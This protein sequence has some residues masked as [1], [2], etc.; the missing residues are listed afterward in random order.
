MSAINSI[1]RVYQGSG[2]LPSA[3]NSS[4]NNFTNIS[5]SCREPLGTEGYQFGVFENLP[6]ASSFALTGTQDDNVSTMTGGPSPMKS[7][8]T[9]SSFFRSPLKWFIKRSKSGD[10]FNGDAAVTAE[11]DELPPLDIITE[12]A[13]EKDEDGIEAQAENPLDDALLVDGEVDPI[14]ETYVQYVYYSQDY[15]EVDSCLA[16]AKIEV[17]PLPK[18]TPI[19]GETENA[20]PEV[21]KK[22]FHP[23][24]ELSDHSSHCKQSTL[25]RLASKTKGFLRQYAAHHDNAVARDNFEK[26][27]RQNSIP[28]K[29]SALSFRTPL[30]RKHSW[31]WSSIRS[32]KVFDGARD[33]ATRALVS[34]FDEPEYHRRLSLGYVSKRREYQPELHDENHNP[35]P[36]SRQDAE[37][38]STR[39]DQNMWST[40]S[41]L[42]EL[43]QKTIQRAQSFRLRAK[44]AAL[45]F[46]ETAAVA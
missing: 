34:L 38:G 20:T 15:D 12:S 27:K 16:V 9:H 26:D 42:S 22:G 31:K 8:A 43:K 7:D 3:P 11:L 18:A 44:R 45:S 5:D 41:Y 1:I 2:T 35:I 25:T 46:N 33:E 37:T 40:G 30:S 32:H 14:Y 39:D 4:V 13:I 10:Y 29:L 24:D 19:T 17:D 23:G 28:R 21:Y 36:I 6:T